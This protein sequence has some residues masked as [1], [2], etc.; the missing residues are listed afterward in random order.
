MENITSIHKSRKRPFVSYTQFALNKRQVADLLASCDKTS[1]YIMILL[2]T[3]YGFRRE[4]IVDIL[5]RNI[6][7][8]AG[9]ITYYEHKKRLSR[10]IPIERDVVQDLVRY[11]NM[12]PRGCEY[13]LPFR[14]GVTAWN[15]L[16][17]VCKIAGIPVPSGRTGRP[18]H[19]LRGTCV[20]LRQADGWTLHEVAALIGDEPDTVSKHYA[21]VTPVELAA[22][23][24]L[25]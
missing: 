24:G 14:N 23:M 16:Q 9:T 3:R 13:L 10:T 25:P 18:F 19:S 22:K 8:K 6:D 15:H 11:I 7:L 5:I 17:E 4:D 21:T 20:K 12:L 1:D 2:A